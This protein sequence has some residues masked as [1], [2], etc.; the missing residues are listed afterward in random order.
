MSNIAA[1][2][3]VLPPDILTQTSEPSLELQESA[4]VETA[5]V[6]EKRKSDSELSLVLGDP[7]KANNQNTELQVSS[8]RERESHDRGD[9]TIT[10]GHED[11]NAEAEVGEEGLLEEA[12]PPYVPTPVPRMKEEQSLEQP[13]EEDILD[14]S[15]ENMSLSTPSKMGREDDEE[16]DSMC[17][18]S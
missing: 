17:K 10:R 15:D 6:Q 12:Y 7:S 1:N 5:V 4:D 2:S 3:E 18:E 8:A 16:P 13:H 11:E 9:E 14:L